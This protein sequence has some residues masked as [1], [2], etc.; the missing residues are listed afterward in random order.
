MDT[1]LGLEVPAGR[2]TT[3]PLCSPTE[4]CQTLPSTPIA[5]SPAEPAETAEPAHPTPN[6]SN[7]L[8]RSMGL[9]AD[10]KTAL[11]G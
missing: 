8:Q 2:P 9:V 1:Q 4:I 10:L 7:V 6:R 5:P 3:P 11:F